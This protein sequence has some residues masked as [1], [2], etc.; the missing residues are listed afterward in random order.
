MDHLGL[1][2]HHAGRIGALRIRVLALDALDD[3][4]EHFQVGAHERYGLLVAV[5]LQDGLREEVVRVIG[6]DH[7]EDFDWI[8]RVQVVDAVI[9]ADFEALLA[10]CFQ[11]GSL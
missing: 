10:A 6:E 2:D 7:G 8:G 1:H 11:N 3:A 5:S 4:S 9:E